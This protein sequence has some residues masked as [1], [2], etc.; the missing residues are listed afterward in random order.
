MY[1]IDGTSDWRTAITFAVG[2]QQ[3][4]EPIVLEEQNHTSSALENEIAEEYSSFVADATISDTDPK[5]KSTDDQGGSSSDL[6]NELTES[7]DERNKTKKG[8]E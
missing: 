7:R 6:V 2:E 1:K 5:V 3:F 4:E 8:K